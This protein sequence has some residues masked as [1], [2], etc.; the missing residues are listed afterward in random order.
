LQ[1]SNVSWRVGADF[2]ASDN[3][4]LYANVSKGYKAGSFPALAAAAYISALPVTQ[5][6]VTAYE[7]GFKSQLADNRVQV[8]GAAFYYDYKDK[9]I[10]G[11]LFD[12]IFG[13]LDTLVNVPKSRIIGVETD[14]TVRPIDPLTVS[15]AA[16]YLNSKIQEYVGYDIFGGIDLPTFKPGQSNTQDLSGNVIPYTPKFSAV[17]NAD[18]RF[19]AFGG[20]PFVG[21][22]ADYRTKQDAAIGGSSSTLPV[23]PRY[24]LAPGVIDPYTIDAYATVDARVG[25]ESEDGKFR[26]MLWGKNI[27]NKYYWTAVIPSSDSSAR[28]AGMPATYGV[29]FAQKFK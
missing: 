24:R 12:F 14:I 13:T 5:E 20:A 18:Y 2:K 28:L 27:L 21:V 6:S 4:L 1:Q 22:T 17:F 25:Y 29:S 3:L 8:N 11:K 26:V 9:Q 23:G 19:H 16:T 7:V 15:F 10:R